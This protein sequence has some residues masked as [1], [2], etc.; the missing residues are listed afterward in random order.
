MTKKKGKGLNAYKILPEFIV[1]IIVF[2][3]YFVQLK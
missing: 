3:L 2:P 1:I